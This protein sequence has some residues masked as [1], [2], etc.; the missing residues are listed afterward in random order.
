MT[1]EIKAIQNVTKALIR[2][3]MIRNVLPSIMTHEEMTKRDVQGT[4]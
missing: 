1:L 4:Y 2:G 3:M